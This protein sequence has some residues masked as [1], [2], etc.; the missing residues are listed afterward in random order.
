[1][2][3]SLRQFLTGLVDYA[4]LFPP[5]ELDLDRAMSNYLTYLG[6]D[7]RW[8]LGPFIVPEGRFHA[9]A[10]LVPNGSEVCRFSV[11]LKGESGTEW[12]A[13][14]DEQLGRLKDTVSRNRHVEVAA[15]EL[16]IPAIASE[17]ETSAR[18]WLKV[19]VD[20][21]REWDVPVFVEAE[22]DEDWEARWKRVVRAVAEINAALLENQSPTQSRAQSATE[23]ATQSRAQSATQSATGVHSDGDPRT[24]GVRIGF[25]VR[26][27]GVVADAF[28]SVEQVASALWWT[29]EHDVPIKATAGLHHP[30]RHRHEPLDVDMHG[31][32][33]V[34]G[35][36]V[37][38]RQG[39]PL[40]TLKQLISETDVRGFDFADDALRW[41]DET[42]TT[43]AIREARP[44]VVSSF[45]SC[46]FDE[47]R[48]DLRALGLL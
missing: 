16:R 5:A 32:I 38:S 24:H 17:D 34:F 19:L 43:N 10:L 3:E 28:P 39:A 25:K 46:S 42:I 45:G 48:E 23:S 4:G 41:R 7:D 13:S 11:L 37:L 30:L 33:N 21:T 2:K 31:F 18:E 22:R 47:P 44:S 20:G 6:S 40:N 1:M 27:G 12:A 9:A 15:F 26:C 29:A 14:L 8:M 35:A 36:A